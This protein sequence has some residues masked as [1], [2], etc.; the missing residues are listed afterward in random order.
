VEF[1]VDN[2]PW[3]AATSRR[4]NPQTNVDEFYAT[5]KIADFNDGLHEIRARVLPVHGVARLLAGPISGN[6]STG[7][8]SMFVSTNRDGTLP[9]K[10]VWVSNSGS[11]ADGDGSE[12]NPYQ[13]LVY[14]GH[15][16][17]NKVA[18]GDAGGGTVYLKAGS[19]NLG[20]YSYGKRFSSP[21]R[22]V[23][24]TPGPGVN[25]TDVLIVSSSQ[26]G[27]RT[28]LVHFKNLMIK[29]GV[30][31]QYP[32]RNTNGS[33]IAWFDNCHF[34]AQNFDDTSTVNW[35]LGWAMRLFTECTVYYVRSTP[36]NGYMVRNSTIEFVADDAFKNIFV[37]LNCTAKNISD[38][39]SG[40]HPDVWQV[41]NTNAMVENCFVQ[42][43]TATDAIDGQ[44]LFFH[45]FT[46][47]FLD[48]AFRDVTI[49][50]TNNGAGGVYVNLHMHRP[51]KH[52]LIRNATLVGGGLYRTGDDPSK[53]NTSHN[54]FS[55]DNMLME[56]VWKEKEKVSFVVPP[57]DGSAPGQPGS[58]PGTL[59]WT[60]PLGVHYR[61]AGQP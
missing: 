53:P 44:G 50:N 33:G 3:V 38:F 34:E 6:T 16:L 52:L 13:T 26:D 36:F 55:G 24:L 41:W 14:A 11:D 32:I 23:T 5:L 10:T 18:G 9:T 59:P 27:L 12:S 2:G 35:Y 40:S 39:G 28:D 19:Y 22:Y 29:P 60:S 48:C 51:V 45:G 8:H 58:W 4:V 30:G 15:V 42:N 43:L 31:V 25:K 21:N 49:D 37:I 47:Q 61:K 46:L 56:E 7:N 54:I 1:S 20:T 17:A 57:P